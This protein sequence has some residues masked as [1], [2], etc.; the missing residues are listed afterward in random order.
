MLRICCAYLCRFWAPVGTSRH[1]EGTVIA[2]TEQQE[3]LSLRDLAQLAFD[4]RKMTGHRLASLAQKQGFKLTHTTINGIRSG[5]YKYRPSDD[6]LRAIAWLAGVDESVA[7]AAAGR[8]AP[9]R[10]FAEDLPPGVDQLGPRERKAAVTMLRA[11]VAQQER[12]EELE[13]GNGANVDRN[14]KDADPDPFSP[15]LSLVPDPADTLA[16]QKGR[17]QADIENEEADRW[18]GIDPP[19]PDDGV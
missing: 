5:S 12:I 1:L 17:S 3:Q 10:P 13:H 16:A 8:P 4:R 18:D 14:S 19:G 6:T 2:V 15:P 7:F 9:G 11:L